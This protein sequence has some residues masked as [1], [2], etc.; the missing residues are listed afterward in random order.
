MEVGILTGQI[1]VTVWTSLNWGEVG[2][3]DGGRGN[4]LLELLEFILGN[5][6]RRHW[7][8]S[9]G[10]RWC[11][12]KR[13]LRLTTWQITHGCQWGAKSISM[14]VKWV[15]GTQK[16]KKRKRVKKSQE[17]WKGEPAIKTVGTERVLHYI[18]Y[19]NPVPSGNCFLCIPFPS[20]YVLTHPSKANLGALHPRDEG[21]CL[22]AP[23]SKAS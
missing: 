10:R 9:Q 18:S 3:S 22:S 13:N 1:L 6:F 2:K 12:N 16:R 17:T 21:S 8:I 14:Q 11:W 23:P 7:D 4:G 5:W 20:V 19:D 15:E